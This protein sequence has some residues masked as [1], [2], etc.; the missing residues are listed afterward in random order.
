MKRI[1]MGALAAAL[2]TGC[3]GAHKSDDAVKMT[4][5]AALGCGSFT[6]GPGIKCDSNTTPPT[7]SIDVGTGS[8]KAIAG[9]STLLATPTTTT[10]G[11]YLGYYTEN[12]GTSVGM[13]IKNG[14]TGS[15]GLKAANELCQTTTL[16]GP[17]PGPTAGSHVCSLEEMKRALLKGVL[18]TDN[19]QFAVFTDQSSVQGSGTDTG[20]NNFKGTCA[21]WTTGSDTLYRGSKVTVVQNDPKNGSTM[22]VPNS[23]SLKVEANISCAT[24][25]PIA[26][27]KS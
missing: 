1:W 19:Q 13:A 21:M 4:K 24:T 23:L 10:I 14:T 9:D 20:E 11:D 7:I 16:T 3:S 12:D 15:I 27:C 2:A 5:Q 17:T 22:D 25:L 26:C 6:A 8:G 18:A